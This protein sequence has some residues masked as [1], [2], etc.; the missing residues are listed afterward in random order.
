MEIKRCSVCDRPF[1]P[2]EAGTDKAK[3]VDP[4]ACPNCNRIAIENS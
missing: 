3:F 1:F 4:T 2:D